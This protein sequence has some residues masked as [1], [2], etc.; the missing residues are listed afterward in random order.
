MS[1]YLEDPKEGGIPS[2]FNIMENFRRRF[3]A[4]LLF[5]KPRENGFNHQVDEWLRGQVVPQQVN[6]APKFHPGLAILWNKEDHSVDDIRYIR[7]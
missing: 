4:I 5:E 2:F 7:V 1:T 6:M 3:Y